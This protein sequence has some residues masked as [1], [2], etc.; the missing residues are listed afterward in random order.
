MKDEFIYPQTITVRCPMC[1]EDYQH[2]ITQLKDRFVATCPKCKSAHGI[3]SE[4]K[5]EDDSDVHGG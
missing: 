1:K 4:F 2:C 3:S 5:P